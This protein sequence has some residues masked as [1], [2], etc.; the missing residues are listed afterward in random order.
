MGV[1]KGTSYKKFC[2]PA[3]MPGLKERAANRLS[4]CGKRRAGRQDAPGKARARFSD[5]RRRRMWVMRLL[6]YGGGV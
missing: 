1:E 4:A 2:E 5:S 3:A 6:A